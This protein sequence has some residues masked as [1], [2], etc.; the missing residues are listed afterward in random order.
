MRPETLSFIRLVK[1]PFKFRL[2][3]L[4]KI[5]SA[6]FSGVRIRDMDE[7]QCRV[8]VP[9]KWFTT[10]P[11]RSTYFACLSMAGEMSTGALAMAHLH[12]RRPAISLLVVG[13]EASY[14]KKATSRI[15]FLC[16]D[17]KKFEQA[18]EDAIARKEP[19]TVRAYSVGKNHVGEI[20][21][22]FYVTWSFKA[23]N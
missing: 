21:A 17:G 1:N 12:L 16:V 19:Q 11:F 8:T 14:F 10:N 4:S 7:Q 23:R 20:V 2:F 18:I 5:P 13:V 15:E 9:F 3:L 22:E 6:F